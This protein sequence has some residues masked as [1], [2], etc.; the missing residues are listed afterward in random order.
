MAQRLLKDT[1]ESAKVDK[2]SANA[3]VLFYR[4]IMKADDYGVYH[5]NPKLVRSNLFP[6][7][8]D[9]VRETDITRWMDELQKAGLIAFYDADSKPYLVIHNFG[10]R[11]RNMKKRYPAPPE[12]VLRQL[13]ATCGETRPEIEE[14]IEIETEEKANARPPVLFKKIKDFEQQGFT[15]N[16][17]DT[18]F[19]EAVEKFLEYRHLKGKPI[20]NYMELEGI[21]REFTMRNLSGA[22]AVKHIN[23]TTTKG[24][25]HIFFDGN[26]GGNYQQKQVKQKPDLKNGE[27][28]TKVKSAI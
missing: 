9:S 4:L 25:L 19:Y 27:K 13:A 8:I 21:L 11:M 23:N 6:L 1:T 20:N 2:L 17:D 22:E 10:Q 24:A 26:T 28:Y 18:V 12:N 16:T 14:E 15:W 7:R 5:A 3:E